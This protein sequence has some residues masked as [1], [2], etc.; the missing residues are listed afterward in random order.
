MLSMVLALSLT[1]GSD[2]PTYH[3][4]SYSYCSSPCYSYSYCSYPSYSYCSY[5]SYS[6]CSYPCYSYSYCYPTY[7]CAPVYCAPVVCGPICHAP[8]HVVPAKPHGKEAERGKRI[9]KGKRKKGAEEE[10]SDDQVRADQEATIVVRLPADA[11]LTVD[12]LPTTSTSD[13]RTFVSPALTPGKTF[14][15]TMTAEAVVNGEKVKST[16][17]VAVRAGEETEVS[18]D[19]AAE[20]AQK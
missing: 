8:Y 6:Y 10:E 2:A 3:C 15:Y 13:T 16:K 19:L 4:Y 1:A 5:P 18:F 7:H 17:K 11:R 12:G 20:V 14:Y 9:E